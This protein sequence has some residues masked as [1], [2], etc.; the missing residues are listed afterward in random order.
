MTLGMGVLTTF[1]EKGSASVFVVSIRDYIHE[2]LRVQGSYYSF[3]NL[4]DSISES[5]FRSIACELQ[6]KPTKLADQQKSAKTRAD[7]I[8]ELANASLGKGG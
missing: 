8:A 2:R 3:S 5:A 6:G 1:R 4:F 7:R